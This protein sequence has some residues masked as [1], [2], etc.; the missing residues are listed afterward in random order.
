MDGQKEEVFKLINTMDIKLTAEEKLLEDKKLLKVC[1]QSPCYIM[2]MA[3]N[4]HFG[5]HPESL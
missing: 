2:N 1:T 5:G 4:L 3:L